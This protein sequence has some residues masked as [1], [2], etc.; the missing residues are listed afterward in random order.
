MTAT[1]EEVAEL[2]RGPSQLREEVTGHMTS[3]REAREVF[4]RD[5]RFEVDDVFAR[6]PNQDEFY[7]YIQTIGSWRMTKH[8]CRGSSRH[9]RI[10]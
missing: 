5:L 3:E 1:Q 9:C 10:R 6:F 2:R 8:K 7:G 4:S